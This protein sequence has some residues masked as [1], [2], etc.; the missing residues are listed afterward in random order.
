MT[1]PQSNRHRQ[2]P[3]AAVPGPGTA[4]SSHALAQFAQR[5]EGALDEE[6]QLLAASA[7]DDLDRVIARKDQLALELSRFTPLAGARGV[8]KDTHTL[9]VQVAGMLD[10]NALL[11][12][13][14]IDAVSEIADMIA[15]VLDSASSDGTY[16]SSMAHV[17][18][19]T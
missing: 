16:T 5:L 14:H 8:D 4:K 13:R 10:Q 18:G 3:G 7:F 17:R 11:L 9:L 19:G 12:K 2:P 6:R 1:M 15:D